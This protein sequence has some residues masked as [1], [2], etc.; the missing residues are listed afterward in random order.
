MAVRLRVGIFMRPLLASLLVVVIATSVPHAIRAQAPAPTK[1]AP[2]LTWPTIVD[3]ARLLTA[4]GREEVTIG[5]K[6]SGS[7]VSASEGFVTLAEIKTKPAKGEW[8]EIKFTNT[9]P[10]RWVRYEAPAGSHAN[11]AELEFYAGE[12][13]IRGQGFGSGGRWKAA[14]DGKPETSF[15]AE[16]A[17]GQAVGLDLGNLASTW[18][19]DFNPGGGNFEKPIEVKL[20]SRT[21]GATIR[22]TLDGTAPGPNSGVAYTG[23]LT[24]E[25]NATLVAVAF[26]DGLAASPPS[27]TTLWVG[28]PSQAPSHSFHVGNSLTGNASRYASFIRTAGGEDRFPAY[29][30]GGSLTVKLWN[31]SQGPDKKRWDETYAK[32]EHPLDTFTMQPRDFNVDQETDHATR[33]IKLIREKSPDVQPWLYVEWVEMN[34]GR[35]TDKG[36]VP[37]FQMKKTFP[38]LTWQESMAAML[39]YNEEVQHRILAGYHEG[40]PVRIIPTAHAL[41]LARSLI[42]EGKFPDVAPGEANFYSLFFEDSVH[43]NPAGCYLVACTWYAALHRESPEGK[44]LPIG[45]SLNAAQARVIQSLAWEVVRNYPDCGL[46]EAGTQPCAQPAISHDGKRIALTSATPGAF[47]RYTLDGTTPTR[48][49]GYIYNGI[50]SVQPGIQLKAVAYRSGLAD[51]EVTEL[52][53]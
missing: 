30:I 42:D 47:F 26:K 40:K 41:G 13:K 45:T 37:T 32:A 33:F 35:P 15:N 10:Y 27:T 50:I 6:I 14:L 28:K 49:T 53:R 38:A 24:L 17:D 25:K 2:K 48:T 11:I 20:S 44:M 34:R 1:A 52:A 43:V 4:A 18:Q 21:P 39:L 22:Y 9:Q 3:R 31:E 5:G 29:L 16:L 23:P 46:Y 36:L 51:S 7:N 19:P 12:N 8:L